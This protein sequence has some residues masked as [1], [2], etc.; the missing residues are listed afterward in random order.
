MTLEF[1]QEKYSQLLVKYQ[2]VYI[3]S[4]KEYV[5]MLATAEKMIF[6]KDKT[7]EERKLFRMFV[8]LIK[9]YEQQFTSM[10]KE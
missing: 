7:V 4:E 3:E 6:M 5:Y 10:F 9:L 2:P 1:D 8:E